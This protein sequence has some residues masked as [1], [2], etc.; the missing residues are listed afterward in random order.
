MKR[1]GWVCALLALCVAC[2]QPVGAPPTFPAATPAPAV[3]TLK[4]DDD[5]Y[6]VGDGEIQLMVENATAEPVY[7]PLCGP[8]TVMRFV[9]STRLSAWQMRCEVDYLAYELPP[10]RSVIGVISLSDPDAAPYYL[11]AQPG[12]HVAE[13]TV[14]TGCTVGEPVMEPAGPKYGELDACTNNRK[15]ASPRFEILGETKPPASQTAEPGGPAGLR[16]VG[17]IGGV[18]ETVAASPE[19]VAAGVGPQLFLLNPDDLTPLGRSGPLPALVRDVALEANR[20]YLALGPAGVAITDIANPSAPVVVG[21]FRPDGDVLDVVPAGRYLLLAAGN[22]GM[23]ILDV[24]NPANPTA[25]GSWQTPQPAGGLFVLPGRAYLLADN[26]LHILD[27]NDPAAPILLG[28]TTLPDS[29]RRLAVAGSVAYVATQR[30]G[31][32]VVDLS[33]ETAPTVVATVPTDKSAMDLALLGDTLLIAD[34]GAGLTAMDAAT[35]AITGRLGTPGVTMALA[36]Q[37]NRAYLADYAGGVRQVDLSI[38]SQPQPGNASLGTLGW[39]NRVVV[40]DG[41]AAVAGT[42]GLGLV[43]LTDPAAPGLHWLLPDIPWVS[44]DVALSENLALVVE[45]HGG[46]HLFSL[47]GTPAEVA[48][49]P[50]EG[51]QALDVAGNLAYLALRRGLLVLDISARPVAQVS[52]IVKEWDPA[53]VLLEGS[54]LY[55]AD[56]NGS[57]WVLDV[58]NPAQPVETGRWGQPGHGLALGDQILLAAA[59]DQGL[60]TAAIAEPARPIELGRFLT[61]D[62]RGV[63]VLGSVGYLA[64][65]AGGVHV[66]DLRNPAEPAHLSTVETFGSPVGVTVAGNRV[67]VADGAGGLLIFEQE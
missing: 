66:I 45:G 53:D 11:D 3:V 34:Y 59:G 62:A 67:Y 55:V 41:L 44:E 48:S 35:R 9:G 29:G 54:T 50:I 4:L 1:L 7:L 60:R 57:I 36:V 51:A 39:V 2:G 56:R 43:D 25:V 19:L 27:V 5:T 40:R 16:L 26:T 46:L 22:A 33:N 18:V 10:G 61:G 15:L 8:W 12:L 21:T 30:A 42:A 52:S 63:A 58:S 47:D 17:Q 38:P 14:Y 64:D 23:W 31:V 28:S 49:Y 65:A 6:L 37:G 32:T 13:V 20:A 24:D